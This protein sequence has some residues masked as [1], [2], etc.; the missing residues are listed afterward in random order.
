MPA[1]ILSCLIFMDANIHDPDTID[2]FKAAS[3]S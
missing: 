1:I 3:K 2:K